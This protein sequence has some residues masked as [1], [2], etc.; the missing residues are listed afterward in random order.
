MVVGSVP[1]EE[2]VTQLYRALLTCS[3][4]G[5]GWVGLGGV[6]LRVGG[7]GRGGERASKQTGRQGRQAGKAGKISWHVQQGGGAGLQS[8][9]FLRR[10][11]LPDGGG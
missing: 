3:R 6:G 1:V 11:D 2:G 8:S 5:M 10:H 4:R 9:Q 7:E